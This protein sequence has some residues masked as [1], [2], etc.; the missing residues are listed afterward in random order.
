MEKVKDQNKTKTR[1]VH[2]RV[3]GFCEWSS[4]KLKSNVANY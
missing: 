3:K 2:Q 1:E 4:E